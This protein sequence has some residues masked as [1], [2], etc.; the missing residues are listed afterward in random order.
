METELTSI[1]QPR[2][3]S[4]ARDGG[5]RGFIA[6]FSLLV[7]ALLSCCSLVM[8]SSSGCDLGGAESFERG[9][10]QIGGGS[11]ALLI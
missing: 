4:G 10:G 5:G 2:S 3:L 6:D 9:A 8:L 7:R 11:E 1:N